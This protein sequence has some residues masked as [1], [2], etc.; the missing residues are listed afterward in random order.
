MASSTSRCDV[1]G[2]SHA[3]HE[4][5]SLA[6]V[7]PKLLAYMQR[8]HPELTPADLVSVPEVQ[9]Y[10]HRYPEELIT[11]ESGD[12]DKLTEDVIDSMSKRELVTK[13]AEK[14]VGEHLT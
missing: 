4:S 13:N 7:R 10:R 3:A 12:L 6:T 1:S 14:I 8:E 2:R 5:L 9:R 11:A